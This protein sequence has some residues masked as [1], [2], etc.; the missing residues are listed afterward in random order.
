MVFNEKRKDLEI[1]QHSKYVNITL[2]SKRL[3]KLA[4]IKAVYTNE[5][6][7]IS[8]TKLVKLAIDNLVKDLEELPEEKAVEYLIK[9]YEKALF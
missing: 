5:V 6:D 3:E 8:T 9:L 4:V 7:S 1:I 2:E